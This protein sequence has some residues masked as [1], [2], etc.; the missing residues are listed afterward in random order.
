MSKEIYSETEQLI[1]CFLYQALDG[2]YHAPCAA[3]ELEEAARLINT[4]GD[5]ANVS[6]LMKKVI[7]LINT[8]ERPDLI[9][10][11]TEPVRLHQL[12]N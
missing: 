3:V 7:K 12:V 9:K 6:H 2:G 10:T 4:L 8:G 5:E 11:A 1:I